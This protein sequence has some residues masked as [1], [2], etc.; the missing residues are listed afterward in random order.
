MKKILAVLLL[1]LLVFS[2]ASCSYDSNLN[3]GYTDDI[4]SYRQDED[5]VYYTALD[6][7]V[8]AYLAEGLSGETLTQYELT[9]GMR[10]T[11]ADYLTLL[12]LDDVMKLGEIIKIKTGV[13]FSYI[14]VDSVEESTNSIRYCYLSEDFPNI[15]N[16]TDRNFGFFFIKRSFKIIIPEWVKNLKT[17]VYEAVTEL[18]NGFVDKKVKI[19]DNAIRQRFYFAVGN[20][21]YADDATRVYDYENNIYYFMWEQE[22]SGFD[23]LSIYYRSMASGWYILPILAGIAVVLIMLYFVK[24]KKK[25]NVFL[26]EDHTENDGENDVLDGQVTIDEILN[27]STE[28][29]NG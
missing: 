4:P 23:E 15:L 10:N 24:G 21:F 17:D 28:D 25:E 8:R 20:E 26:T 19:D 2:L 5:G 9:V 3:I 27:T 6:I 18:F 16:D 11:V 22:Q 12:T 1:S 13:N 29:D 7:G 14:G